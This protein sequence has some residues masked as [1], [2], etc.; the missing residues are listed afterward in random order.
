MKK[1]I[2]IISMVCVCCLSIYCGKE[3]TPM[4]NS[5]IVS[6]ATDY[7][8]LLQDG[9]YTDAVKN[10]DS[11]M[12]EALP[13]EKLEEIWTT[14]MSQ[15]GTFKRQDGIRTEKEG[16]YDI[17]Y[18]SCEFEN[19]N[20][21]LKIVFNS[22]RQI[23]GMFFADGETPQTQYEPPAYVDF[24]S[25]EERPVTINS[26]EWPLPGTLTIP[27]GDGPFPA[28][29]LVHGSGPHDRDE[30]VG[31]N[32][33]FR[34]L[35]CGLASRGIAVLCYDKRTYVYGVRLGPA[36]DKI[37]VNEETI[38]DALAAVSLLRNE[39]NII[40]E[41]IFV[42]GHSL[43]GMLIPRIGIKDKN[44]AGFIVMAGAARP[45]EDVILEQLTYLFSLGD[46][47]LV[48]SDKEIE[49]IKA[50]VARV[51]D[52]NLSLSTPAT[53]LPLGIPAAYWLDL[54]GYNPPEMAKKLSQPILILQGE[55]DY[56]VSM[57]DFRLWK[58]ALASRDNV[59][60][61]SY[62]NLNHLFMEGEGKS[63]PDDYQ[64]EGHISE[65]VIDDIVNWIKSQ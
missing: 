53:D 38:D 19:I 5:D 62:P 54:R 20:M 30:T 13:P 6:L 46:S 21:A 7:F 25:F 44:I 15:A 4:D 9:K 36:V 48:D 52:P 35:A 14:F 28:V 40:P 3:K 27:K 33:P 31:P 24:N 18:I 23:A 32:K 59:K 57:E 17:V 56:Q 49:S 34:D 61:K 43:G 42:L 1:A 50:Q 39:K 29:I 65:D 2:F 11:T 47:T 58:K 45:L 37:T 12:A 55:R 51:K 63:T 8:A 64:I 22:D 60:F 10:Y 16:K 41:K 26:G